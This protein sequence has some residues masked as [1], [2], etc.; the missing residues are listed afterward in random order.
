MFF[1]L[2]L[3]LRFGLEA[4][5]LPEVG[6]FRVFETSNRVFVQFELLAGNT[7]DGI[8]IFRSANQLDFEPVGE[9]PGICGSPVERQSFSFI[10][11]QPIKNKTLTYRLDFGRERGPVSAPVVVYDFG[12]NGHLVFRKPDQEGFLLRF[13]NP[14]A[15]SV[16]C[17]VFSVRGDTVSEMATSGTELEIGFPGFRPGLYFFEL[18]TPSGVRTGTLVFP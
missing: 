11:E 5:R 17:R 18:Q 1:F 14:K 12:E 13:P 10:D 8:Q 4:Q 2:S 3:L 7:C 16:R 9:F 15:E 6:Y